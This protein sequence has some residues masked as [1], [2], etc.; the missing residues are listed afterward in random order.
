MRFGFGTLL[1]LEWVTCELACI[2]HV[3][4]ATKYSAL[5]SLEYFGAQAPV[6]CHLIARVSIRTFRLL[7][8]SRRRAPAH[9][10]ACI[11]MLPVSFHFRVQ[12]WWPGSAH[13]LLSCYLWQEA[14]MTLSAGP[15][16]SVCLQGGGSASRLQG[17]F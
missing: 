16:G 8:S 5:I 17:L 4:C 13:G 3:T 15:A 11:R 1:P 10:F 9:R 2:S 6:V 14:L 7:I 12:R